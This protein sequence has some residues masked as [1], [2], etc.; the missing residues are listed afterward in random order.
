MVPRLGTVRRKG[1]HPKSTRL[2]KRH[3]PKPRTLPPP[4]PP[5]Q[6]EN[7]SE[8]YPHP[9]KPY[10]RRLPGFQQAT[11]TEKVGLGDPKLRPRSDPQHPKTLS[12][13]P[14]PLGQSCRDCFGYQMTFTD[15]KQ[16]ALELRLLGTLLSILPAV[17]TD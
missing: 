7:L 1:E 17:R 15:L 13:T 4:P 9:K 11:S 12:T 16:G 3:S 14:D 5:T 2:C 6:V 10:L 8:A